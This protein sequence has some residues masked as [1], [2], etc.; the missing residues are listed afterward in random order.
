VAVV[1][2]LA[3]PL[4]LLA[5]L[6]LPCL[7]ALLICA[8]ELMDRVVYSFADRREAWR[9]RRLLGR[10]ERALPGGRGGSAE[11]EPEPKHQPIEEVAADLRRLGR[12]RLGVG[13]SSA[14]WHA[15]VTRAYDERLRMACRCLEVPE[16][17]DE[18]E[19]IDLEIERIRV[20]G[21]LI[22]AGLVLGA[23]RRGGAAA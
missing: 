1:Q 8:D 18:L 15:A 13:A 5:L 4:A 10:L 7:V 2:A 14:F 19:G 9:E 21:E 17:L 12:Q 20:E 22:E 23:A 3:L 11:P 6:C 16:H